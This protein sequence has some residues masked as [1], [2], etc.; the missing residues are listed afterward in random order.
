MIYLASPLF[1]SAERSWNSL[2][3][4]NLRSHG[5][6]VWN[7]QDFCQG[8]DDPTEIANICLRNLEQCSIIVVN[9]DGVDV[10]SGTAMEFGFAHAG[11]IKSIAYRTDIRR[12]G[13]CNKNCNLM[14]ASRADHFIYQPLAG[15][16]DI[17]RSILGVIKRWRSQAD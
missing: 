4:N 13:D 11:G 3:A 6:V 12:A 9:C 16:S 14:I 10:E 1:T 17:G 15:Y 8:L 2:L 5:E 7:P